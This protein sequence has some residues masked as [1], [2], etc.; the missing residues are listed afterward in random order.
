M[1][2]LHCYTRLGINTIKWKPERALD[3]IT[4]QGRFVAGYLYTSC[5]HCTLQEVTSEWSEMT[6]RSYSGQA[7]QR[8]C[9]REQK[10]GE[11]ITGSFR[12]KKLPESPNSVR[13]SAQEPQI[14]NFPSKTTNIPPSSKCS[15][16]PGKPLAS[17]TASPLACNSRR[18]VVAN[19]IVATTST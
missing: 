13:Y 12:G 1:V 11:F 8:V 17:R 16:L 5:S 7:R 3:R 14:V 15:L 4:A 9:I 2:C 6:A 18:F 10:P 19:R